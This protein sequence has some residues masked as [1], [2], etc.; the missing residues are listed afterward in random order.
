MIRDIN[1]EEGEILTKIGL[2]IAYYRKL[3]SL[4]Q[5]E[6]ADKAKI[7]RTQASHLE[8]PNVYVNP[9]V[10]TLKRVADALEI[11]LHVLMKIREDD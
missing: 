4:T 3:K 1:I 9:T 6:L 5:N 7:S 11:P 8:A 2:N 10:I